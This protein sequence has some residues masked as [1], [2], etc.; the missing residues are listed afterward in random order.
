[1]AK[2]YPPVIEGTIP[3]FYG[4][5]LVVPFSMNRA[6]AGSDIK[7]FSLK[8]KTVQT[9]TFVKNLNS[10]N[11]TLSEAMFDIT[12]A[13]LVPGQYYKLQLA[14]IFDDTSSTV[15]YYSTVGVVKYY[16]E[17]GPEI[18]VDGLSSKN[19]NM[20]TGTYLGVF[21]HP[22]DPMEKVAQYRFIIQDSSG[23][24][25]TDTGWLVHNTINDL[26][27]LSSN[28]LFKYN[29]ELDDDKVYYLYYKVITSNNMECSTPGYR[30]LQKNSVGLPLDIG[31]EAENNFDNGYVSIKINSENESLI[32]TGSFEISRQ[33]IKNPRHWEPIFAFVL[34]GDLP[35][36]SVWKDFTVEQG[37]TYRY[38]I[39][40]FNASNLYSERVISN[41]VYADFEDA[42]LFDGQRQL[43]IKYNP[44][45]SSFKNDILES[46]TDTIG[47]KYPFIFRNGHVN[48][49]EFPISGLI[50]YWSDEENLFM[51]AED[52]DIFDGEKLKRREDLPWNLKTT[53]LVNY[54][55]AAERRFKL[56]ALEWLT[57]GKP[58]LFRSPNEGNYIVRLLN[59]SLTPTDTVGR[60]L[61]TFNSTAYEVSEITYATLAGYGFIKI[62]LNDDETQRR[63]YRSVLLGWQKD[64]SKCYILTDDETPKT[65][66]DYYYYD[67]E[68]KEYVFI[69]KYAFE[70]NEEYVAQFNEYKKNGNLYETDYMPVITGKNKQYPVDNDGYVELLTN[71]YNKEEV[72]KAITIRF[73]DM[74]SSDIIYVNGQKRMIGGTGVYN[75]DDNNQIYSVKVRS[76]AD[77]YKDDYEDAYKAYIDQINE[78]QNEINEIQLGSKDQD[79]NVKLDENGN[80]IYGLDELTIMLE[81]KNVEINDF[82]TNY[83]AEA[84][85][86]YIQDYQVKRQELLSLI[87]Q[88]NVNVAQRDS[89]Q[90]RYN[91]KEAEKN[92]LDDQT[93]VQNALDEAR[94]EYDN[95]K[96]QSG[97]ESIVQGPDSEGNYSIS[98]QDTDPKTGLKKEIDDTNQE[99]TDI[100]NQYSEFDKEDFEKL[101]ERQDFVDQIQTILD[102]SLL[103]RQIQK[104]LVSL[105]SIFKNLDIEKKAPLGLGSWYYQ[106]KWDK[107]NG[108][109]YVEASGS[110]ATTATTTWESN[111]I[112]KAITKLNT[113]S[114]N[115]QAEIDKEKKVLTDLNVIETREECNKKIA[116]CDETIAALIV[117][118]TKCWEIKNSQKS[119]EKEKA[120]ADKR[121]QEIVAEKAEQEDNK[122]TYNSYLEDYKKN[123]DKIDELLGKDKEVKGAIDDLN[124]IHNDLKPLFRLPT[125]KLKE[126]E[127]KLLWKYF[128]DDD[129]SN[130]NKASDNLW[131][132]PTNVKTGTKTKIK[133]TE[134]IEKAINALSSYVSVAESDF[135]TYKE[136]FVKNEDEYII[137]TENKWKDGLYEENPLKEN[138][139]YE[140]I[141]TFNG[142][143]KKQENFLT[144]NN[145]EEKKTVKENY[146]NIEK[147]ESYVAIMTL[148]LENLRD[149]RDTIAVQIKKYENILNDFENER[150]KAIDAITNEM[151]TILKEI[152]ALT[153]TINDLNGKIEIKTA[154]VEAAENAINQSLINSLNE[155]V[156]LE[157]LQ[158]EKEALENLISE[159]AI[160]LKNKKNELT[161]YMMNEEPDK[162]SYLHGNTWDNDILNDYEGVF[163]YSYIDRFSNSFD[164]ITGQALLDVP[165]RQF[166]SSDTSANVVKDLID[167]RTEIMNILQIQAEL[168]QIEN[169]Y[170]LDPNDTT[171]LIEEGTE[172]LPED[173]KNSFS[174]DKVYAL[175]DKDLDLIKNPIY[176]Y[177][178]FPILTHESE[179]KHK[180]ESGILFG[181]V[182]DEK[183]NPKNSNSSENQYTNFI[184]L[185]IAENDQ[186]AEWHAPSFLH[187]A[188][189]R[190]LNKFYSIDFFS[191]NEFDD[192]ITKEKVYKDNGSGVKNP[193]VPGEN[194]KEDLAYYTKGKEFVHVTH[195]K[196]ELYYTDLTFYKIIKKDGRYFLDMTNP[197]YNFEDEDKN[198]YFLIYDI[199]TNKF[200]ITKGYSSKLYINT[201]VDNAELRLDGQLY[202]K[203]G[204][205]L[206][207]Y[208]DLAIT[209]EFKTELIPKVTDIYVGN[210][211]IL[212]LSYHARQISYGVDGDNE[213]L[214]KAKEKWQTA[215]NEYTDLFYTKVG[216][217]KYNFSKQN[218]YWSTV[219]RSSQEEI[220]AAIDDVE[221]KR[222]AVKDTYEIYLKEL[223]KAL[224]AR[225]A[226]HSWEKYQ[227]V[228]GYE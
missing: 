92:A 119:T 65:Y 116:A 227:E 7:G 35:G 115:L 185:D 189:S 114:V 131:G 202:T 158:Q 186:K 138:Y 157:K 207:P 148:G 198:G 141:Y 201:G 97:E 15:G 117:E 124:A 193:V 218:V 36:H 197:Y 100:R 60:M 123:Y 163:T 210:G 76:V 156:T 224:D 176:I 205:L 217:D 209:Q 55:I 2:L 73:D 168:K 206:Q 37:E 38:C 93:S 128:F 179:E 51:S 14:Y 59:T 113:A 87:N 101:Q 154:E 79:G 98:W 45:V 102:Q 223:Q 31:L 63:F 40:Q 28:D 4:T 221:A 151:E 181:F 41:E 74:S 195:H 43:K 187:L 99:I 44:K 34:Q 78:Y 106:H 88:K 19:S 153:K 121:I 83:N 3:A 103:L 46:K 61:H 90:T 26:N 203:D 180:N 53:D 200:K 164:L 213:A 130:F 139:L 122:E 22:T 27:S 194:Y 47:S 190:D 112:K 24:P 145:Y 105:D 110:S 89:K 169:I 147:K 184:R 111:Y 144:S 11:Y 42:F 108:H 150:T 6:V 94:A 214:A 177:Q 171:G 216:V 183:E 82:I 58:K 25:V 64:P 215:L 91:N 172:I 39:R 9:N 95:L 228:N 220:Q 85:P 132:K 50:S 175:K 96:E 33:N 167:T 129:T 107:K 127:N 56:E 134:D 192:F 29:D 86:A 70:F 54:N 68:K 225:E 137:Y 16:G 212:N 75:L 30:I 84:D 69:D 21:E 80:P 226:Q 140:D 161:I 155:N 104:K 208:L 13:G 67:A 143:I 72:L 165:C 81:D 18:Y 136:Y 152:A 162:R 49:K 62:D 32:L 170:L 126:E 135:K 199:N 57:N 191:E 173:M 149:D 17:E 166:N 222:Q 142:G 48:Y 196:N 71:P 8:I 5:T 20:F 146:D 23:E 133:S 188:N 160:E 10:I 174:L 52:I 182:R 120:D 66:K 204:E 12:D 125:T 159:K 1:M 109:Y 178:I 118:A 211:V 77:F 219:F